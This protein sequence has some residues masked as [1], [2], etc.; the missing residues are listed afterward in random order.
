MQAMNRDKHK[1]RGAALFV[2]L[3]ILLV[4]TLIG[5]TSMSG[6]TLQERMAGNM[7]DVN[8][9]FQAAEAALRDGETLLNQAV[10]PDFN[11]S[12]GLYKAPA[13]PAEPVWKTINWN[14]GTAVRAYGG[15]P[16]AGLAAQPVYIIEELPPVPPA[17]GTLAADEPLG[18]LSMYRVTARAVGGSGN[19]VVIL[20][21]IYQ[22]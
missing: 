16:L 18:E 20:Q 13:P 7:R 9:A 14:D 2:A 15:D 19:A 8:L 12:N 3:I 4:L 21:T 17:G 10:L 22:R 6:S 1:Q 5:V 11:G